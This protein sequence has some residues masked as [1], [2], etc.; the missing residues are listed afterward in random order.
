MSS[1][2]ITIAEAV[3]TARAQGHRLAREWIRRLCV[4]RGMGEQDA[5]GQWTL[6]RERFRRWLAARWTWRSGT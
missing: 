6:D 5:R 1:E 2:R 3:E 4:E